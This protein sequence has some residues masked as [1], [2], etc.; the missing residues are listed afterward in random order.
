MLS[1]GAGLLLLLLLLPLLCFMLCL[2][3]GHHL[4]AS[5]NK[6]VQQMCGQ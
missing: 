3:A 6:N 5:T 1:A 4:T 2:L